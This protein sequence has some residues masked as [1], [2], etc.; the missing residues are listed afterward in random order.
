MVYNP[1]KINEEMMNPVMPESRTAFDVGANLL[2]SYLRKKNYDKNQA[3]Q[4]QVLSQILTTTDPNQ[5]AADISGIKDPR[6]QQLA[7]SQILSGRESQQQQEMLRQ[8]RQMEAEAAERKRLQDIKDFETKE[9]IK[10][11]TK[12]AA[13]A[14]KQAKENDKNYNTFVQGMLDLDK[15]LAA[16]STGFVAGRSPAMTSEQRAAEGAIANMAPILKNLFRASGEGTFTDRDQALL[17]EM[18]PSRVD[19]AASRQK[20][21]Q[22]VNAIVETKLGKRNPED[23]QKSVEELMSRIQGNSEAVSDTGQKIGRFTVRAL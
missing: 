12:A 3:D 20:K 17:L 5:L 16:T 14:E 23:A 18:V 6:M 11:D 21:M 1:L 9:K 19:D 8:Q 13:E 10:L 15:S 2:A 7:Y 4:A 22:M